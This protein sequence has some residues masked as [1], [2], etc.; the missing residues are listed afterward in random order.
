MACL[1][2]PG[3]RRNIGIKVQAHSVTDR[4]RNLCGKHF[5]V[6]VEVMFFRVPPVGV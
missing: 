3:F 2:L 5:G 1:Q 4:M 6:D